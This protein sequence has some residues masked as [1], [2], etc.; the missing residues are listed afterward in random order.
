MAN[1]WFIT[2]DGKQRHGPFSDAQLKQMASSDKI[3]AS[4]MIWR[5]GTQKWV[6]ASSIRG[7]F[8]QELN[9]AVRLF[10]NPTHTSTAYVVGQVLTSLL[11][12]GIVN[13]FGPTLYAVVAV[14]EL[15]SGVTVPL[16][17]IMLNPF[18]QE[19]H[20]V[21]EFT[22]GRIWR[23]AEVVHALF[24]LE[25]GSCPSLLLPSVH[26][27]DEESV[28][29]HAEFLRQF[30]DAHDLLLRVRQHLGNPWDRVFQ[31][32]EAAT[33]GLANLADGYAGEANGDP[34]DE[35]ETREFAALL[36]SEQH[37]KPELEAFLYAWNGAIEF[38]RDQGDA[39]MAESAMTLKMFLDIFGRI[40]QSCRMF[41]DNDGSK[42]EGSSMPKKTRPRPLSEYSESEMLSL[43]DKPEEYRTLSDLDLDQFVNFAIAVYGMTSRLEF[44]PK[45]NLL[46]AH[47]LQRIPAAHRLQ[48][49]AANRDLVVSGEMSLNGLLPYLFADEDIGIVSTA[50]LDYTVLLPLK[51]NDPLT[52]P[53]SLLKLIDTGTLANPAAAI[54]GMVS[55][56]DQRVTNLLKNIRHKLT[57]TEVEILTHCSTGHLTVAVIEF[58]LTWL[59]ELKGDYDDAVFGTI[60]AALINLIRESSSPVVHSIERVFP[61]TPDNAIRQLGNW[62][63]KEYA[64]SVIP[65]LKAIAKREK[66]PSVMPYVIDAWKLR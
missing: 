9:T 3:L 26:L 40:T 49:Y 20:K 27:K 7:L 17:Q 50:A 5:E 34:L 57:N 64:K 4:D 39:A 38:Q 22:I 19:S 32:I 54:G 6:P 65:R 8:S 10:E 15:R 66:E 60:A 55:L 43:L 12:G 62:P 61:S 23:P 33:Y 44:I 29:V 11:V 18:T 13:P 16:V 46:Y 35:D 36:L 63:L 24:G 51:G 31:E 52:G 42:D 1:R 2:R 59:E 25:F 48:N 58:Y 37:T 45:I 56:G 30:E 41:Q 47:F 21:G 14:G 53:K 28:E